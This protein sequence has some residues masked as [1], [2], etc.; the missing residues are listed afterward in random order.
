M[1]I[2]NEN[3]ATK[4]C[5][6]SASN[7]CCHRQQWN[8]G[9]EGLCDL[10]I[11][12]VTFPGAHNAGSD[13]YLPDSDECLWQNQGSYIREQFV[14]GIRYFD[15]DTC[16]HENQVKNCHCN[17]NFGCQYGGGVF[18]ALRFLDVLM[19]FSIPYFYIEYRYEVN[20]SSLQPWRW[21]QW[22]GC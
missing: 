13:P 17:S 16:W 4:L 9:L 19:Q 21:H 15:I 18:E 8:D 1:W 10:R 5:G 20:S 11:D 12:Q 14:E 22:R 3:G 2:V 7:A 6:S